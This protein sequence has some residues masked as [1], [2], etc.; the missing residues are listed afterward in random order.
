M[1]LPT[2]ESLFAR[3]DGLAT[4]TTVDAEKVR[5]SATIVCADG[6]VRTV[7]EATRR[8][9][10][11]TALLLELAVLLDELTITEGVES[12]RLPMSTPA[13]TPFQ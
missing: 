8:T 7:G 3:Q 13:R 12:V 10:K 9:A 1:E 11:L 5:F 4:E 2:M 6:S